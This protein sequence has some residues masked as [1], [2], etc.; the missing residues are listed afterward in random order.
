MRDF[1]SLLSAIRDINATPSG[2]LPLHAPVFN[3]RESEYVLSAIKSTFVSSVGPEVDRFEEMLAKITGATRAVVCVNGTAAL[4]MGLILAGVQPGDLVLTQTISFVATANAIA[5]I[6]ALPFF[7]DIDRETLGL[8]PDAVQHFLETQC[9]VDGN[10]CHHRET[11]KRIAACV[12]MHTFGHPVRVASLCKLCNDWQIPL[13]EDAAEALGSR[14][15]GKHC[16]TFG[17]A[18]ALSFNGN[19]IVTTGGGGALLFMDAAMGQKAKHLTT[20]AKVPHPWLYYHDNVGWNFRMPNLNAALGC[21]QL[22]QLADFLSEKR[23]RAELYKELFSGDFAYTGWEFISE[24]KDSDSNYWLC[25]V[26]TQNREE[27]DAFLKASNESGVMTRPVW[28]PLHTLPMYKQ[29]LHDDL[30]NSMYCA[31]RLVNLPSGVRNII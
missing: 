19:K 10:G 30:S 7:L 18:G 24:P 16:G 14:Y 6:H 21:A 13:V 5:H 15:Q 12:P 31:E 28:E 9:A 17:F 25:A 4:E 23:H 2:S 8:S 27:R 3:G 26:L 1:S 11:G 20:T 22:E 29:C